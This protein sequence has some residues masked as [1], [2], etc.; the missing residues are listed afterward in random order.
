MRF[1][2]ICILIS[3]FFRILAIFEA[4][5]QSKSFWKLVIIPQNPQSIQ[6]KGQKYEIA[7]KFE[8]VCKSM[9]HHRVNFFRMHMHCSLIMNMGFH[10]IRFHRLHG[11]VAIFQNLIKALNREKNHIRQTRK[12]LESR[13]SIIE[14]GV[15]GFFAHHKRKK[16]NG[17]T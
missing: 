4:R 13:K 17:Q 8:R 10:V 14:S 3:R 15:L 2:E 11:V 5:L 7:E 1:L 16:R 9:G 6:K 12:H